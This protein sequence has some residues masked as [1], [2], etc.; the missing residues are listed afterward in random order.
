MAGG[1][2]G[3]DASGKGRPRGGAGAR[4]APAFSGHRAPRTDEWP[5]ER[6]DEAPPDPAA[7]LGAPLITLPT[8]TP[9]S[10]ADSSISAYRDAVRPPAGDTG[11]S[12]VPVPRRRADSAARPLP[13][14]GPTAAAP[15][16]R[17]RRTLGAWSVPGNL[18][19]AARRRTAGRDQADAW[20]E[21]LD[22][23]ETWQTTGNW[24]PDGAWGD[25]PAEPPS[26]DLPALARYRGEVA[27]ARRRSPTQRLIA[28][29]RSPWLQARS[30]LALVAIVLALGT[31]LAS[32]A[33]EPSQRFQTFEASLGS[34][35]AHFVAHEVRALTSL[36]V[37]KQYDSPQQFAT[38][39]PAACSPTSM[40]MV[41]QAWGVK[42]AT[43]G[44]MIDALGPHLSPNWGLLDEGGF[45][46]AAE[47]YGFRADISWHMTYNQM[48]YL[49]NEL[50][51]PVIV[52]FR[53][54]Y[55]YYSFFAGGHFLVVTGGD[56]QGV[57]LADGSEYYLKYLP[58]DVFDGLWQW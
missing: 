45:E 32:A 49:T 57:S 50:G 26:P 19:G 8:R 44:H 46:Y 29:A 6:V 14:S 33:G 47:K 43:I 54:D 27:V 40:A 42:D 55:G 37:P 17:S 5:D 3:R 41:L 23:E 22:D 4:G 35:P 25:E 34:N 30:L 38:Y 20:D 1:R 16:R 31:S 48:L 36:L 7:G 13:G 9:R 10:P 39:S 21:E 15:A 51:I 28:Q 53:R 52:N 11:R 56:Q 12:L 24:D 58:R 18:P 2:K